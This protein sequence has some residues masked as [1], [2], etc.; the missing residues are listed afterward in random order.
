[1]YLILFYFFLRKRCILCCP[2]L[3]DSVV[4]IDVSLEDRASLAIEGVIGVGVCQQRR[5]REEQLGEGECGAPLAGLEDVQAD[6]P[7]HADVGVVDLGRERHVGWTEGVVGG[8]LNVQVE[9][10]AF[11]DTLGRPKKFGLPVWW[12][13]EKRR[14]W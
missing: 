7:V 5:D 12:E 1:M 14:E 6:G 2:S 13:G 8:E 4:L 9:S 3:C 11:V 10:T